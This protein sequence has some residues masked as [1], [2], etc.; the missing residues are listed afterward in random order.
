MVNAVVEMLGK[1]TLEHRKAHARKGSQLGYALCLVVVVAHEDTEIVLRL[2]HRLEEIGMLG[3]RIKHL[4]HHEKLRSLH[5]VVAGTT[6]HLR[7]HEKPFEQPLDRRMHRQLGHVLIG[8]DRIIGHHLVENVLFAEFDPVDQRQHD[9][10]GLV[11]SRRNE[12]FAACQA[13]ILPRSHQ[14][15]RLAMLYH[16]RPRHDEKDTHHTVGRKS[17]ALAGCEGHLCKTAIIRIADAAERR[18][19]RR[20]TTTI[21]RTI[22][23]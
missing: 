6:A 13:H 19:K 18:R 5:L 7:D 14:A 16:K 11:L 8:N 1:T 10:I 23:L 4:D 12:S 15:H 2:N 9:N 21:R 20:T 3:R 17:H 22:L